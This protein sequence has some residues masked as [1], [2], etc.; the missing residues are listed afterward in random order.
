MYGDRAVLPDGDVSN[1]KSSKAYFHLMPSDFAFL[2]SK[3]IENL[4]FFMLSF[5]KSNCGL[6]TQRQFQLMFGRIYVASNSRS[7]RM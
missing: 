4:R 6:V 7:L 5:P 1:S 3:K 2:Q